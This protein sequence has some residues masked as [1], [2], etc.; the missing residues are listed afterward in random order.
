MPMKYFSNS[1]FVVNGATFKYQKA[2]FGGKGFLNWDK[3]KGFKV[4]LFVKSE[5]YQQPKTQSFGR[6][7]VIKRGDRNDIYLSIGGF[8][9]A[10]IPSAYL[11]THFSILMNGTLTFR[12]T[13]MVF[14]KENCQE[15]KRFYGNG[16]YRLKKKKYI[17]P[18][19]FISEQQIGDQDLRKNVSRTGVSF[20]NDKGSLRAWVTDNEYLNLKFYFKKDEYSQAFAIN[21]PCGFRDAISFLLGIEAVRLKSEIYCKSSKVI[22]FN[23]LQEINS[24]GVYQGLNSFEQFDSKLVW[25]LSIFFTKG[26]IDKEQF[27]ESYVARLMLKQLVEA[28][29]QKTFISQELLSATIL[30][31]ALRTLYDA[32]FSHEFNS[33]FD[34]GYHL[35]NE[36]IPDYAD[37]KKWRKV[38]KE[39]FKSF[40]R[41]RHRNAHPDWLTEEM[42]VY[43]DENITDTIHDLRIL[44]KFYQQMILLMSGKKDIKAE[45]PEG[46]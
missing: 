32:P 43:S 31:A 11:G 24:M 41:V 19:A 40:R 21:F 26:Y 16:L 27:K 34:V 25:D 6:S 42:D 14:I 1:D 2:L 13:E 44:I 9:K 20:K 39:V 30:E 33:K 10:I 3:E 38:R 4:K 7:K 22:T 37:G 5:E 28:D 15:S 17:L 36:F 45:L 8:K 29:Q 35:K 46:L 23:K 18:D 12:T